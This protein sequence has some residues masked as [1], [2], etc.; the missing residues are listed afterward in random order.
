MK[1]TRNW[2]TIGGWVLHGLIAGVMILAGSLKVFGFFP[3]EE[4]AKLVVM[5]AKDGLA[6]TA[7]SK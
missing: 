1:T 3:P 4:V 6:R 2:Q 7:T 5:L